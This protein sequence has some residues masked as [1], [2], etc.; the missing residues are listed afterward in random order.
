MNEPKQLTHC[1]SDVV[2][3][4][5]TVGIAIVHGRQGLVT[6][7]TSRVPYLELDGCVVVQ[8]NSLCEE[9]GADG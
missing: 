4:D 3:H 9:G 1:L 8:S 5:C 7:L 2:Y 6:L